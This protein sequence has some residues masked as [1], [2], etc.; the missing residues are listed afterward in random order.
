MTGGI[1]P[2]VAAHVFVSDLEH[3][4]L[5]DVDCHHL[6]RVLRLRPGETVTASDG[7]GGFRACTFAAG[8]ALEPVGAVE[9]EPG[10][11]VSIGVGFA[12]VKGERPEWIVQKLTEC[13]VDRILPFVADRSIVRWDPAR[14]DRNLARLRRVATEAAM[15]S[16]RR[17]LPVVAPLI[18]F[19]QVVGE[20]GPVIARAD[21]D[22]V[23]PDLTMSTVLVGPEG[24]WSPQ[25]REALPPSITLGPT[26]MR[27]E[28]AAMAAGL[29]LTS[30][31]AGVVRPAGRRAARS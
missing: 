2:R 25:E 7:E 30:L 28:T 9:R 5:A 10:R 6:E 20:A 15:Q 4:E 14:A 26:V 8:G 19:D 24:G 13:G 29:L 31:R 22:G 21:F 18:T 1:P 3:P 16:R 27:A 23:P 11:P 12:L 17:W